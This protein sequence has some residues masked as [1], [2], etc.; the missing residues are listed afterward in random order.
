MLCYLIVIHNADPFFFLTE[1]AGFSGYSTGDTPFTIAQKHE[2][3]S[4]V[5]IIRIISACKLRVY[6]SYRHTVEGKQFKKSS[7]FFLGLGENFT[8]EKLTPVKLY[9][10]QKGASIDLSISLFCA[11]NNYD[12]MTR[13][14]LGDNTV[15]VDSQKEMIE[16]SFS[17]AS[18]S[19]IFGKCNYT[20]QWI[21]LGPEKLKEVVNTY[22]NLDPLEEANE[23]KRY[24]K[25]QTVAEAKYSLGFRPKYP[26]IIIPGLASTAL[27][28][29]STDKAAWMRERVWI[30][31]FKIGK[32][33]VFEK[34][35]QRFAKKETKKKPKKGGRESVSEHHLEQH[36]EDED[37]DEEFRRK[38]LQHMV[39][40]EDGFSDPPGIRVRAVAGLHGCDF[41]SDQPV[42]K[43]K[44]YVFGY[45]IAAL[46][47]VGYDTNNLDAET[48]DWRLP[49]NKLNERDKYYVK[50]KNSIQTMREING[51]K[52]VLLAHS[53]GNRVVQY[54]L[55]WVKIGIGQEW[56]DTNLHAY[57]ALGPP[58]LGAPKSCRSVLSGDTMDLEVF[59][60]GE[61]GRSMCRRS[62]SLPWL[63][64]VQEELLPDVIS[65]IKEKQK[66]ELPAL[67]KSGGSVRMTH[68]YV[69]HNLE[70][71]V[72]N[73]ASKSWEYWQTFYQNDPLF[74]MTLD[75]N[76]TPAVLQPPPISNLWVIYGVNLNTEVSFFYKPS[77]QEKSRLVLD[78]SADR[79]SGKKV[80]LNPRGLLIAGGIAYETKTTYQPNIRAQKSGDGTIPFSSLNYAFSWK[81]ECE[82]NPNSNLK[83]VKIIEVEGV[84]HRA[85][86]IHEAVFV[87][88]ID[89]V[90]KHP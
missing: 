34:V 52:V 72:S 74:L 39:L 6:F 66:S 79:Y 29:W 32:M 28:A 69:P 65:R 63:F 86:L 9:T 37:T 40:A 18:N 85:M 12:D 87:N 22:K 25:K 88:V 24:T 59:L 75:Q 82:G 67:S 45:L 89:L 31:P 38:W 64:P 51:E 81:R 19:G 10:K 58:F 33:A 48:Y 62:S 21:K 27:E 50:L 71:T 1:E 80:F 76:A 3:E 46:L 57:L 11:L 70:E 14:P 84:E 43:Q 17:L 36:D 23:L 56:I 47:E 49:P 16:G 30:D 60:T 78:P 15:H 53:M 20:A 7:S 54:F 2:N 55:R 83:S 5:A 68:K 77:S 8:P 90:C 26:I 13:Y 42:V 44:S 4:I 35:S 73:Y 61:E 41:L